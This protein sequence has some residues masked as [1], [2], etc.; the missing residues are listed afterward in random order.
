MTWFGVIS[1]ISQYEDLFGSIDRCSNKYVL[2]A[3]I[4]EAADDFVRDYDYEMGKIGFMNIEKRVFT[5]EESAT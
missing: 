2:I 5:R 4:Q 3:G 1:K